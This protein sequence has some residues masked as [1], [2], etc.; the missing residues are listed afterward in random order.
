MRFSKLAAAAA[1]ATVVLGTAAAP[2][3][4]ATAYASDKITIFAGP[5]DDYS[6]ILGMLQAGEVVTIDRCNVEGTWCR[7]FH[8]GPTGWVLASYLIG[9]QAKIDA[10]PGRSIPDRAFDWNGGLDHVRR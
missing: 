8:S 7:V 10:T 2:A 5:T 1:L 6:R 4:A 3:M 9:A